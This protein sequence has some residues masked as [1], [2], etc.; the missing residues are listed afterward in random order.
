MLPGA[1]QT[2]RADN[3]GQSV[4]KETDVA[5]L[6]IFAVADSDCGGS[7]ISLRKWLDGRWA[8]LFSHPDDFVQYDFEF[9]RWLGIVGEAFA[10]ACIRPLALP[11]GSYPIDRGWISQLTGGTPVSLHDR[12]DGRDPFDFRAR[13]LQEEIAGVQKRFAMIID[14]RLRPRSTHVYG[15]VERPPSPL[16]FLRHACRLRDEQ[17]REKQA[18]E[19]RG[20]GEL[21]RG[22]G[23]ASH[24]L[25]CGGNATATMS[26]R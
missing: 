23:A 14:G 3:T 24:H 2:S 12:L 18:H 6:K 4:A 25:M 13:R 11:R 8:I 26:G 16:D 15:V 17:A 7:N 5:T 10:R 21:V 22:R 19:P 1:F 20:G 9:D